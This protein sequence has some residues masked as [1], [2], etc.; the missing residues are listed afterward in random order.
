MDTLKSMEENEK[1]LRV[2][3]DTAFSKGFD[4][5]QDS[6]TPEDIFIDNLLVLLKSPRSFA[7]PFPRL[8]G[9]DSAYNPWKISII[10]SDDSLLRIFNWLSPTTG[11][12]HHYPAIF[13]AK[14][15]RGRILSWDAE[16]AKGEGDQASTFYDSLFSLRSKGRQLY[17]C[18]GS[19]QG[20]GRLP[21]EIAE[22]YE[23]AG[24][25]IRGSNILPD[26]GKMGS[27][28]FI[29]LE[30]MA[31][32]S[33]SQDIPDLTFNKKKQILKIPEIKGDESLP[34]NIRWTGQFLLYKFDGRK[35]I[36]QKQ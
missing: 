11:T 27:S 28:I 34:E 29:D 9:L 31:Y 5:D 16:G 21:F 33:A 18:I 20:S 13:Q 25:S 12:W 2:L 4:I 30:S 35:F 24:D 36:R 10:Y 22:T 32:D 6:L 15:I 17:L 14:N 23:I 19:G 3:A 26:S 8:T 7:Y 1:I